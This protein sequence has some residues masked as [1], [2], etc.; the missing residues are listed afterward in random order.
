MLLTAMSRVASALT[1]ETDAVITP[2]QSVPA[3]LTL[4]GSVDRAARFDLR[5]GPPKQ[6]PAD[7][8]SLPAR[9]KHADAADIRFRKGAA[10]LAEIVSDVPSSAIDDPRFE[11]DCALDENGCV[12]GRH[13]QLIARLQDDVVLPP[14]VLERIHEIDADEHGIPQQPS[15]GDVGF[16]SHTPGSRHEA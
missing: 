15:P 12:V 3:P 6:H 5:I 4:A 1:T 2:V 10:G 9:V 14:G 7:G 16:L 8:G 13:H 11:R